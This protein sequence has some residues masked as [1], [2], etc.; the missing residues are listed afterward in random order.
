MRYSR[1]ISF[2]WSLVWLAAFPVLAQQAATT[3]VQGALLL[4]HSFAALIG[5]G[6]SI[7][8]VTLS[9]TARRIT[10]SEDET[11]TVVLKALATGEAR[12]DLSF[13]S[14]T[15]SEVRANSDQG[16]LGSWSAP[17]GTSGPIPF[18]NLLVESPWFSPALLLSR[19]NSSQAVVS[20]HVGPETR[21]NLTVEHVS[22]SRLFPGTTGRVAEL[23]QGLSQMD[24]YLDATTLLPVSVS[25]NTHPDTNAKRDIPV[26]ITFSDYRNVSGIQIPYHIQKYVQGSVILDLQVQQVGLNTRLSPTAFSIPNQVP[27]PVFQ[28]SQPKPLTLN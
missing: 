17:D 12:V 14:S 13:P 8:D 23:M 18:H 15:R 26:E 24:F 11:G 20:K 6:S 28:S 4:Q 21:N 2:A 5:Q 19:V 1:F 3:N 7:K 9:G 16:P 25:F 10:G 22:V 27:T